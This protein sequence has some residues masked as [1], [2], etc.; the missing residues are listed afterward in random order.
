MFP[1][2][3]TRIYKVFYAVFYQH[4]VTEQNYLLLMT[5]LCPLFGFIYTYKYL[6]TT[7]PYLIL[8]KLNSKLKMKVFINPN[9]QNL[10]HI[11]VNV[12]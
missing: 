4:A 2:K 7:L 11:L 10:Q 5:I 3:P 6:I 9:V 12:K 8:L 1:A